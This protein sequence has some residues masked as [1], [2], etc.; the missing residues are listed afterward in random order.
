MISIE[1]DMAGRLDVTDVINTF[2]TSKVRKKAILVVTE[3]S[4]YILTHKLEVMTVRLVLG[5]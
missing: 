2:A 5:V 4:C 3:V 1:S